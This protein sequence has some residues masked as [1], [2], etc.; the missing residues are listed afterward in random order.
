MS[1]KILITG[2]AGFVGSALARLYC[3]SGHQVTTLDNLKR[4]G[5]ELNLPDFRS[6]GI[7]FIHGD[8][9][10]PGDLAS[11][12]GN[13]D[14]VVE[15]SAE[16]SVLAGQNG[17]TDYLL[18]TN[19]G[20]TIH[21]LD[22]L[23]NRGARMV[24]LSTS[25]VYAV[26]ALRNIALVESADRLEVSPSQSLRGV[27]PQGITED[28]ATTGAGFRSL[29]G[30]TKLA[31]ELIIEEY[32]SSFGLEVIVNRC[33]VLAGRGQFGKTDQ[34]V[35]TLWVARHLLGGADLRYQGFGGEGKQVRD[36]LH[37]SDLFTLLQ[38]QVAQPKKWKGEVYNVGGGL[39]GS[40]SLKE[41]S[42]LCSQRTGREL[43]IGSVLET[44][45]VDIPF[46]VSDFRKAQ[47]TFGWV[48]QMTPAQIVD[49][50]C[51]WIEA[52]R[53]VLEPLFTCQ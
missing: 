38:T 28:F 35:F 32:V 41:Y 43:A 47:E 51:S 42:A 25:R 14:L 52:E 21:V 45:S 11:L 2:G 10:N 33:G 49:D 30:T 39:S 20:G 19:L 34:G 1:L 4:R 44:A 17:Q 40:V 29:Y 46:Y 27:S 23:K 12:P 24:F 48:P 53:Q 13:F 7:A 26:P 36:L 3:E 5:S 16:P 6:R 8:V 15:A 50:I 9:R 18:D 22:F 37:P 31:S